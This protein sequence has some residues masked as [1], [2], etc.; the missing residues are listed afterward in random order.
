[1]EL[2]QAWSDI[3]RS[4]LL[5]GKG[6]YKVP[7]YMYENFHILV[8][9]YTSEVARIY[10]RNKLLQYVKG[11]Y[12][13]AALVNFAEIR[14]PDGRYEMYIQLLCDGTTT[15]GEELEE[16]AKLLNNGSTNA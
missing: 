8:S 6:I 4:H 7:D 15:F 3:M 2:V 11:Y 13:G 14:N 9:Q 10:I 12:P 5:E 1:M 16:I